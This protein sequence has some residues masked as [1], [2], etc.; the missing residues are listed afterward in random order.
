MRHNVKSK[1]R[2]KYIS[3]CWITKTKTVTI[4]DLPIQ[5]L[6]WTSEHKKEGIV[7][8]WFP[9][10]LQL[11]TNLKGKPLLNKEY[12]DFG[13]NRNPE[14]E[15]FVKSLLSEICPKRTQC[16]KGF[17][18]VVGGPKY[19]QFCRRVH[20]GTRPTVKFFAKSVQET[21]NFFAFFIQIIIMQFQE[22]PVLLLL[23]QQGYHL[24][25]RSIGFSWNCIMTI[26]IK[27]QN[28]THVCVHCHRKCTS[29]C[30]E[31]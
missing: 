25:T 28:H 31:I 18:P 6:I 8:E 21:Y 2:E 30:V 9:G 5:H 15:Y 19:G 3:K 22:Y 23:P 20:L 7:P 26:C 13:V 14:F 16:K 12:R 29:L 27:K 4:I 24:G 11:S 10:I 17:I 1:M